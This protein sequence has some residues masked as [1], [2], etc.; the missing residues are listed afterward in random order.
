M[1]EFYQLPE[2][3]APGRHLELIKQEISRLS[4]E[5][6]LQAR[7]ITARIDQLLAAPV[8]ELPQGRLLL[9]AVLREVDKLHKI[10]VL[11]IT[12]GP[13]LPQAEE[14][15]LARLTMQTAALHSILERKLAQP[16]DRR[17]FEV[18]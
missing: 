2:A 7:E 6:R 9:A 5:R 4:G 12:G 13:V 18:A 15:A 17:N 3:L 8:R 16:W 10:A 11:G 1:F 14:A